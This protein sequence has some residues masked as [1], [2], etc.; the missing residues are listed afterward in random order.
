MNIT[1]LLQKFIFFALISTVSQETWAVSYNETTCDDTNGLQC[2]VCGNDCKAT[3]YDGGKL[4]I[5]GTGS[6]WGG[7]GRNSTW[8]SSNANLIQQVSSVEF[9]EGI[10]SIGSNALWGLTNIKSITLADSIKTIGDDGIDLEVRSWKL[11]LSENS[12]LTTMV[13]HFA[14]ASSVFCKGETQNCLQIL[15]NASSLWQGVPVTNEIRDEEGHLVGQCSSSGCLKYDTNG[16]I[17]GRYDFD[18]NQIGSYKYDAGGNL[19]EAVENGNVI[20]R[21]RIYTPLEATAAVQNNKNKF[22]IIYR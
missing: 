1:K 5:S 8:A 11:I 7:G 3:L 4:I 12:Q 16:N 14:S 18:G 6:M 21:R 15:S 22:S 17:S 10:T 20:Y 9:K 2:W 19:I 13:G